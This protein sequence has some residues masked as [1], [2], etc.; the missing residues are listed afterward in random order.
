LLDNAENISGKYSFQEETNMSRNR[1][2]VI[3]SFRK[4]RNEGEKLMSEDKITM[5]DYVFCMAGYENQL[6][7]ME[8]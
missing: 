6:R 2:N 3:N 4:A 1:E 8:A 7:E 5:Q